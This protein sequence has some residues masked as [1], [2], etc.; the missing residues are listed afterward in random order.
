MFQSFESSSD[1]TTGPARLALLRAELKRR[2]LDG[3][4]VP[5]ADEHQGEYIP[6]AAKRLAWLTGFAGAAG[7]AV[8]LAETAAIF[9]DGRYTLQVRQQVDTAVFEPRHLV[10]DPP[11][12]WLK[13]V[14]SSGRR[15]GF[16]PWLH[17]SA[18][19][20][21]FSK[22]LTDVGAAFVPVDGNPVDAVWADR[23]AP[24]TGAVSLH[25]ERLAGRSAA[26]KIAEIQGA[27][28]AAGAVATVLTQPD[29]IAWLLNLRG[30]DVPHTPIALSF[31]IVPAEGRPTLFIDGAKLS[32]SV[33][34]ALEAVADIAGPAALEPA[35]GR[36]GAGGAKVLVDKTTAA[37]RVADLVTAG[38]GLVVDGRD[39]AV[40]PKARKTV[41]ELD[42]T[43]EAHARDGAAMVRFLAWFD[44]EAP[45]GGLTEIDAAVALEGFRRDTGVLKEIS[46]DTISGA[47]PN[48][49]IPH[50]RVSLESNRPI[51]P[52]EIY[53]IDSGAQYEDGTTDITRTLIVGAATAEMRDRFT[54][55]L[56]G[57][58]RLAMAVFPRGTVGAQLD[59]LARLALWEAGLDFDHGTGHGVGAYLSV[60][61]GPARISKAGTVA[62]EPGMILS[63]EPGF[64]KADAWGIRIENLV[65]VSEPAPLPGGERPMMR[66]ETI[67]FAPIDRRLIDPV[68]LEPAERVWLD[69]YHA[70]VRAV[71]GPRIDDPADLAWLLEATAPLA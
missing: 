59:T 32:N 30:S 55:V 41:A 53:L 15:I 65:V 63:N 39:P 62:L 31:S 48:A 36:L 17:T 50:Y 67:T 64:Y 20:D 46:F 42:G 6:E 44:R 43:R 40:M 19:V 9:V 8:V 52:G 23:P 57:H 35:I 1:P 66:L 7:L 21:R 47:G 70:E 22:A 37:Y 68:L 16:D 38:G 18:E 34:D 58:I 11:H 51:R 13:D 56:K 2:G 12:L 61:E 26:D 49:A 28:K 4:L 25:P 24:P 45:K 5:L 33:R 3:F 54:R 71:V 69:A 29:S 60:H 10:D 14:L 27:V